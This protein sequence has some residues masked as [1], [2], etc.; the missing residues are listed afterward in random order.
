MARCAHD[1]CPASGCNPVGLVG[2]AHQLSRPPLNPPQLLQY[3]RFLADEIAAGSLSEAIHQPRAHRSAPLIGYRRPAGSSV[4][5]DARR[6]HDVRNVAR[7]PAVSV[8][9]YSPPLTSMTFYDVADARLVSTST[10]ATEDPQIAPPVAAP[11]L[12]RPRSQRPD[13]GWATRG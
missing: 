8:H 11:A 2:Y 3:T 7:E 6:V 9:A 13:R 5:F 12:A 1:R 10:V 4:A